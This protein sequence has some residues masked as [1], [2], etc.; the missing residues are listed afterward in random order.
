MHWFLV[1]ARE[2]ARPR[3]PSGRRLLSGGSWWRR[4]LQQLIIDGKN[5]VGFLSSYRLINAIDA[6]GGFRSEQQ[7]TVLEA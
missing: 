3:V 6:L 2:A 7:G 4:L 5:P 1:E